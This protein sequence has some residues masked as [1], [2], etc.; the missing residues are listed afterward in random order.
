[1]FGAC[2]I[3]IYHTINDNVYNP[4]I[5]FTLFMQLL[6]EDWIYINIM[7]TLVTLFRAIYT[8]LGVFSVLGN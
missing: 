5:L 7:L 2:S 3:T 6:P 1:M 4:T 8:I